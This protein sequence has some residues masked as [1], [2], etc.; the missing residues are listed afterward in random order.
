MRRHSSLI[1]AFLPVVSLTLGITLC[2]EVGVVYAAP[3]NKKIPSPAIYAPATVLPDQTIRVSIFNNDP[4]LEVSYEIKLVD[5]VTGAIIEQ[6]NT[7]PVQPLSGV[8]EN[9]DVHNTYVWWII[10]RGLVDPDSDGLSDDYPVSISSVEVIDPTTNI[11]RFVP[12]NSHNR[13]TGGDIH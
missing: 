5:V 12:V 11:I 8:V 3:K 7:G 2:G 10:I 13:E 6:R 1:K 4:L 9:H